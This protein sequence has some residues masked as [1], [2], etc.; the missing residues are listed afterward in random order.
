MEEI[1]NPYDPRLRDNLSANEKTLLQLTHDG[2]HARARYESG[3]ALC[4]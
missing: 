1:D 2:L 4:G 3:G